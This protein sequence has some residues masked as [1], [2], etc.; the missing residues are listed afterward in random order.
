LFRQW[1]NGLPGFAGNQMVNAPPVPSMQILHDRRG[2]QPISIQNAVD[3]TP[4]DFNR[5]GHRTGGV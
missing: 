3:P 4:R 2:E 5:V 1:H